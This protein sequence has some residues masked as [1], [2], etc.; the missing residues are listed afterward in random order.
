MSS[1]VK[2]G[3]L[4]RVREI[5]MKRTRYLKKTEKTPSRVGVDEVGFDFDIVRSDI[6]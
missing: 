5:P 2:V 3:G 6:K 4:V 1:L